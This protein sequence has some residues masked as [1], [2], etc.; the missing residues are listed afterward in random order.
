M[1]SGYASFGRALAKKTRVNQQINCVLLSVDEGVKLIVNAEG[2]VVEATP[3][4]YSYNY[5]FVFD[6]MS[7][8]FESNE[9]VELTHQKIIQVGHIDVP[10]N[11]N[12]LF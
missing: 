2:Y 12:I 8:Y 4:M 7:F 6:G 5:L 1:S 9:K 3:K 10:F 11:Q